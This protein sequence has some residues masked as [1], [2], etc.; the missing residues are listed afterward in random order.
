MSSRAWATPSVLLEAGAT[1]LN[2]GYRFA[3]GGECMPLVSIVGAAIE[4][5]RG[6][7]PGPFQDILFHAYLAFLLQHAAVSR[8]FADMAFHAAGIRGLEDRPAELHGPR[9]HA[10]AA[11]VSVKVL[12]T[13]IVACI[14]YKLDIQD[15]AVRE[16]GGGT[17][18]TP[19]RHAEDRIRAAI[20]S[21]DDLRSVRLPDV[22]SFSAES[23]G[24]SQQAASRASRCSGTCT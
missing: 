24:T 17:R 4:R 23:S 2:T 9:G 12:E 15:Q 1:A 3:S 20:M 8:C 21:A 19:F 18:T 7:S 11:I 6:R 22:S 16:Q 10:S 13:Y 14:L 5:I